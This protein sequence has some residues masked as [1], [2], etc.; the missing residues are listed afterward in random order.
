MN[1][2]VT[3][4][5]DENYNS[6]VSTGMVLVDVFAIWCGPCQIIGPIIDQIAIDYEN[7][8][9]VGKLDADNNRETISILGVKSIPTLFLYKDGKVVDKLVGLVSKDKI[10]EKINLHL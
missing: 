8:V 3:E 4:L 1:K 2:F 6:F 9:S 5:T 10:I 7:K